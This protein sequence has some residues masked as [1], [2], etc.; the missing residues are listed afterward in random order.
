MNYKY[1]M[2]PDECWWGGTSVD[3]EKMPFD[4]NTDITHD[5]RVK[6][7][8]QTMPM[9]LSNFGRCIWS[10]NP[11]KVTF[12]DG[13]I[14]VIGENV[15]IETFGSTLKE[16]YVGAMNKHFPPS[17][18]YLKEEFFKVPQYNTWMQLVYDQN[19]EGVMDY[20]RNII[21]H[22]YKPGILM[23]DEGWQKDY[24]DWSFD[25]QKFPD[26]VGMV[27]ELHE[28][29][30]KVMLWVVPYVTPNGKRF[31]SNFFGNLLKDKTKTYFMREESGMPLLTFWWNGYSAVLDFTNPDDCEFLDTQLRALMNDIGI[32]GFKFDGGTLQHY[33]PSNFWTQKPYT[34]MITAAERNIAWNKFGTKYA[35]HEYKDTFK[36]GGKRSIQRI[37][38]RGHS[39]DGDGI[40][41][42]VPNALLQGIIGHPFVC[43]D[44]IG[45]GSWTVKEHHE[46]IDQE[47]FVRMAQCS[48]FFPMMQFS[49]APWEAV[50][51]EHLA[52]IK[53]AHDMHCEFGDEIIRLVNK[54]YEDG[55]PIM[56]SLEY[57]YPNKGY[58]HINDIFMLGE[59]YLIAPVV[60]KG[61]TEKE[62]P[63]PEGRWK[64]YDGK[65][66]DGGKTVTLSVTLEDLPYFKKIEG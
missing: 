21:A 42:L 19:Q 30:F 37:C 41:S 29:G 28:M 8:N 18:E 15:T 6:A 38:D 46:A 23:I 65:I 25:L 56:R 48:V 26:P 16:A 53:K 12:K 27:K 51:E 59:E 50:D 57:N 49:W 31:V 14:T 2:L 52:L 66:Y 7:D 61:Q 47:L 63:L 10:E 45:G 17:G 33:S 58:A 3:G 11:F 34:S 36:G 44:M 35:Y 64:G 20:A 54:A 13:L 40:N 9:Y 39:W 22:G 32:D 60:V 43:P 5:F 24:G 62:I 55:E 4:K 1:E